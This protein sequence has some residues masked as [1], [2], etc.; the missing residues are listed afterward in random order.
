MSLLHINDQ[1]FEQLR[2]L[3][4]PVLVDFFATWCGPCRMIA[5]IISEI[6]EENP[7]LTVAKIDVDE[8]PGLAQ[9]FG[10][11]SIPTLV[12]LRGG[13]VTATALGARPKAEI[14]ALLEE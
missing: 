8:A 10:I 4:G 1:N 12:V 3:E 5:P 11:E 9:A 6:A 2:S 13:K 14:L 7:A